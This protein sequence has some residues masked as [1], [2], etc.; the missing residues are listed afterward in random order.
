MGVGQ[1]RRALY[2]SPMIR[3]PLRLV[4]S[5]CFLALPLA[6]CAAAPERAMEAKADGLAPLTI[7]TAAGQRSFRVELARTEE[8]QAR[9]LMFRTEMAADRGML[10]PFDPPRP[11]SFWMKNTLIPLDM[12][13]IRA[14]GSIARIAANTVPQS[15]EPVSVS[16]PVAAVLEIAGGNA[17]A[18]GIRVGDRVTWQDAR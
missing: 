6:G 9:G 17:A 5:A 12:L 4:A 15:L 3:T 10:F 8:E 18:Q 2:A 1:G 16:E 7:T 13:F 11:A 14:D